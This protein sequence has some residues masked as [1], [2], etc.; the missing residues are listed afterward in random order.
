MERR[1]AA[2][3]AAD[4]VG[5]G[6]LMGVNE[7]ATLEALSAHR[8]ELIDAKIA[9]HH[10]RIVKVMG[11]G[12]LVEFPS[13]VN[14]VICAAQIQAKM[15]ERNAGVPK[16]LRIEFR[17][18]VNIGDV[19]VEGDD[20]FGDG[21]NVAVRL[22][23]IAKRG[24][25][26]LSGTVRDHLGNR[27]D[28]V[29]EDI[30]DQVLKNID[31]P[32]RVYHVELD[33]APRATTKAAPR[34]ERNKPS[35]A[36]LPFTNISGDP[37]QEYFADGITEDIITDLSKVSGLSVI[38]R[39]SVF[40]YKGRHA[41]VQE[42]GQR[43]NVT[44][45]VEGSVRRTGNRV[46]INAELINARDGTHLWADRYD[47]D[48]TDI[49]AL[50][51]EIT[52]T[53]VEQLKVTLLPQ[54]KKAIEAVPTSIVDAYNFYLRGRH[55]FYLRTTPHVLLAQ[56]MF[57]KAVELDPGY[58]RA[59]AGLADAAWFLYINDH[60][61]VTVS[62]IFVA[63]TKALELDPDLAEAHASHGIA[64]H[65]LDRYPEAVVE[66]ER[67][68]VIDPNSFWSHSHYANAARDAGDLETS[69]K[70]DKRASE[71]DPDDFGVRFNLSQDYQKLGRIEESREMSR[72]GIETAERMSAQ[73]PDLSLPS[74]IGACAL[75]L[76]GERTRALEWCARALAI[77]PDDPLTLYNVACSY[78]LMGELELTLE[79]LERWRS[80]ANAK[81]KSW[82]HGDTD[83]DALRSNPQF[84][85]FL[86]RLD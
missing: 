79:V 78:A 42:V 75:V 70:M 37:E 26:A 6:R 28:L 40:T 15:R 22:E 58:A 61:G 73:H 62:D 20:I 45:I 39:N 76:L 60:E 72:S 5:Y 10:G 11:D 57:M 32:V 46:R 65:Y 25:I 9:E 49:F 53:I 69:V 55:L 21:V 77:A 80:R 13:V 14:A 43:F 68:L 3:L 51:D 41:D 56:R 7:A 82:V 8:R 12:L 38:A 63:S 24:G 27:L 64:L 17:I 4:V 18:G 2:I 52:K 59:Y 33:A 86:D 19:I 31:R 36:V 48:L 71:I 67:A 54:E 35:I 83:F 44:T 29:F 47:R 66:F 30:G 81:T 16:D 1:L 85:A 74:A 50:Q 84:Q 23:G 34:S